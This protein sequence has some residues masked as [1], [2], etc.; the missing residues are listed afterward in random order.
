[1]G[2]NDN[3]HDSGSGAD[4]EGGAQP[5]SFDGDAG[6]SQNR[7]GG[8]SGG[9]GLHSRGKAGGLAGLEGER[10]I[11]LQRLNLHAALPAKHQAGAVGCAPN[12]NGSIGETIWRYGNNVIAGADGEIGIWSEGIECDRAEV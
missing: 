4:D 8:D 1:M 3:G 10:S 9:D 11:S 2:G 12:G 5:V 6:R 7:V